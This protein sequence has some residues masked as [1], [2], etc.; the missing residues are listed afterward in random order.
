[1]FH[2][3]DFMI[4]PTGP[5]EFS[6]DPALLDQVGG[7]LRVLRDGSRASF[8]ARRRPRR[9]PLSIPWPLAGSAVNPAETPWAGN[10]P[11]PIRLALAGFLNGDLARVRAMLSEQGL[12]GEAAVHGDGP[13][14]LEGLTRDT[15][16]LLLVDDG[17]GRFTP[18][19]ALRLIRETG[20]TLPV[21]VW[22]ENLSE[23]RAVSLLRGGA[24]D[25]LFPGPKRA[26]WAPASKRWFG[27]RGITD[28]GPGPKPSSNRPFNG[29]TS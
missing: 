29:R 19:A 10:P 27:T 23:V 25:E 9:A 28:G 21:L 7:V 16:D 11:E 4:A 3:Y 8:A 12:P 17:P 1:M 26:G 6:K 14:L 22:A 13:A 2:L 5:G 24:G 20:Q 15:V 18:E